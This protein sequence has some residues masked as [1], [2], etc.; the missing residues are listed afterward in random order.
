MIL[1]YKVSLYLRENHLHILETFTN[2]W[3]EGCDFLDLLEITT[4]PEGDIVRFIRQM[5]DLLQ[6]IQHA[7]LDDEIRQRVKDISE[8]IDRDVISVRF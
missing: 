1:F 4:M 3:Y 6:Q 7:T 5:L 8:K 2:S